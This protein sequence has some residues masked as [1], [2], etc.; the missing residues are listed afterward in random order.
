ELGSTGAVEISWFQGLSAGNGRRPARLAPG[1]R[2]LW[3]VP[4][5]EGGG[6]FPPPPLCGSGLR[7]PPA[8]PPPQPRQTTMSAMD[9]VINFNMAL[10]LIPSFRTDGGLSPAICRQSGR[11][12]A[13]T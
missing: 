2:P 11:A 13:G 6:V 9:D 4:P 12:S 5:P 3:V 10:L 1:P 7:P 8:P